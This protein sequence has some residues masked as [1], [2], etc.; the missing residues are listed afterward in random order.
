M[1]QAVQTGEY[2]RGRLSE[3][4]EKHPRFVSKLRGRGMYLSFDS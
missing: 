2:L 4:E 3:M 1:E